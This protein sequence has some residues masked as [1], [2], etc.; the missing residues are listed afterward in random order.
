MQQ[1]SQAVQCKRT[2][3]MVTT[4][5]ILEYFKRSREEAP[6]LDPLTLDK[7]KATRD[8]SGKVDYHTANKTDNGRPV[9]ALS[10]TGLPLF[11]NQHAQ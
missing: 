7:S 1:D 2:I 4:L 10:L 5:R 9:C 3:Q 8:T 11:Y 6:S